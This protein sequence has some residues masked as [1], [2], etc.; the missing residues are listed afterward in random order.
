MGYTT[1]FEGQLKL[2]RVLDLKEYKE[3][4]E[5]S[6]K[7]WR[8]DPTKPGY[9][10]QWVVTEDGKYLE[11]DGNEKFYDYVEWLEWLIK[12]FF[13]PKGIILNGSL[14]WDGEEKGDVGKITVKDNV[15]TVKEGKIVYK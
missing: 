15:V 5:I 12:N 3:M 11:W 2:S 9:Y 7:D 10:C 14:E 4:E 1:E 6:S 13:E 8:D